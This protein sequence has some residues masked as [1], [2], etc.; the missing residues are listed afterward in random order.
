[1]IAKVEAQ[2]LMAKGA[3]RFSGSDCQLHGCARAHPTIRSVDVRAEL[4]RQERYNQR[5]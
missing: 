1:M 2:V 4:H 5:A 3:L